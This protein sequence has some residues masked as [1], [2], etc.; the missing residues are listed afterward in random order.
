[1]YFVGIDWADQHHDICIIDES[2]KELFSFRIQHSPSGLSEFINKIKSVSGNKEDFAI[3]L[4]IKYSL[5]TSAI[6]DEG[7][8]VYPIN[9]K[10]VSRYRDR[11]RVSGAKT[12]RIDAT[13]LANILRTDMKW[14]R[15]II[16][17]SELMRELKILTRDYNSLIQSHTRLLNKLISCLKCYYPLALNLFGDINSDIALSFLEKF[18]TPE[19]V[20]KLTR[21]NLEKFLISHGY[22]RPN[23]I[24]KIY[25]QIK[26]SQ[27]KVEPLVSKTK[28]RLALALV[29]QLKALRI[30]LKDY[31]RAI[32]EIV[33]QQPDRHI[34]KSLPGAGENL[35]PR[36][37]AEFGENRDRYQDFR[38][39]Q[40]EAGTAPITIASGRYKLARF[41]HACV[42][43]F[44]DTLFKFAF[45]SISYSS[46]AR[47][48]YNKQRMSGKTHSQAVRA[49]SN[50]W[51]KI[52]FTMWK[53]RTMYDEAYHLRMVEQHNMTN[54][55]MSVEFAIA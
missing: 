5:L 19:E 20:Q 42:K 35:V 41:R 39:V 36:L 22:N 10:S 48:Y 30:Q 11:Y 44:R 51:A 40:C 49:L 6:L 55:N 23:K 31:R 15:P 47:E 14:F 16:P 17:D 21:A 33:E 4:E 7:Y 53:K 43:P 2:G 12:D 37:I 54:K 18:S 26:S 24:D 46:W 1:M 25:N 13:V 29:C 38:S 28:R 9:P 32:E 34:F 8:K 3:A 27:F 52:I 50:K 45:C